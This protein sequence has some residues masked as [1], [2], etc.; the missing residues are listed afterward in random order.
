MSPQAREPG[1][2][3][4]EVGGTVEDRTV[5]CPECG[6]DVQPREA[7]YGVNDPSAGLA[8]PSCGALLERS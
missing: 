8:C 1:S 3:V 4:R 2:H 6:A 5:T 7:S